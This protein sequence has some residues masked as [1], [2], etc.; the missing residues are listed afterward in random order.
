MK[1]EDYLIGVKKIFLDTAPVIYYVENHSI[2]A[3]VVEQVIDRL[4]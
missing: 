3:D 2:Y 4:E 1:L